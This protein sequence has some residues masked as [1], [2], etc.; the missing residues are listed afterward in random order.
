MTL[1]RLGLAGWLAGLLAYLLALGLIYG[2]W[3]SAGDFW[4]VAAWS[5]IAFSLCYWLLYLPVLR[6]IRLA[7][8]RSRP[9]WVFAAAAV[10][11]GVLPSALI[12]RFFGGSFRQLLTPESGLLLILFTAVGLVVGVGFT[13]LVRPDTSV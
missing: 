11:M 1:V 5:L 13:R 12:A 8:P 6:L 9:V 10:L 3:I 7:L 2:E 4:A